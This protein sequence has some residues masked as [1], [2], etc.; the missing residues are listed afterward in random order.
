MGERQQFQIWTDG[1]C[2]GN[3]GPGG[4][5]YISRSA[6]GDESSQYDAE[7]Q[8]TNNRMELMAVI[9]ALRSLPGSSQVQLFSDSQYVIKGM[10]EWIVG[11]QPRGWRKSEGKP[12]VNDDLWKQLIEIAALHEIQW[13]WVRGHSGHEENERCDGLANRAIDEASW[14]P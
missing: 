10:K 1:A 13:E 6:S 12:V 2:R 14:A 9:E 4:W 5:G 3:P 8:T 11:W 7:Q